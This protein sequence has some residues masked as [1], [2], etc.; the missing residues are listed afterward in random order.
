M[1]RKSFAKLQR[2]RAAAARKKAARAGVE[3]S[4]PQSDAAGPA[5]AAAPVDAL[6]PEKPPAKEK[7]KPSARCS[8]VAAV[9][10]QATDGGTRRLLK[11]KGSLA[12]AIVVP[13]P[14]WIEPVRTLF[15]TRFGASWE[16]VATDAWNST[17]KLKAERATEIGVHLTRGRPVVGV[18]AHFDALPSTLTAAAD[19]VI[20]IGPPDGATVGRAIQMFTGLKPPTDIDENLASVLEF[21]DLIAAFRKNSSPSDIVDRL[22]KADASLRGAG[23]S[24]RLPALETAVEYGAARTWGLSLVRDIA[25]FKAGRIGWQEVDRGAVLFSEPG[26]GKSLYARILAK[27]CGVPLVAF[28]IADLFAQGPGY[29]DSV[30]KNSRAMFE[31]AAALASPCCILFLDEIDALP[32]RATMSSRGAEWWTSVVTDFLLS[33]DSAVAGKRAGIVVIGATNNIAGVDAAILRPGRLERSIELVRPDH[34]GL[35]NVLRH[36]LDG[37]LSGADLDEVGHLMAGSTPAEIMMAVR[38]GRRIARYAGREL[39]LDDLI[40]SIAPVQEIEP[41]AL[42]RISIHEA[43]HAVSLLAVPFGTLQRCIIGGETG[44]AGRTF[45]E[46]E[47]NDLPTRDSIER[48]AVVTLAGR[49]AEKLLLGGSIALGS[50]GD[51]SSD[52]AQVTQFS[53]SLHASTGLAGTLIYLV[54]RQDALNAVR[55]DLKLRARVERHMRALHRR[56]DAVVRQNRDAIVAVAEQLRVRRRLTGDEIR[57]IFEA[58][59]AATPSAR[60][61]RH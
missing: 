44:S 8:L 4:K 22:R 35:V 18:A 51:D 25:D 47:T 3:A 55:S 33:L 60:S 37:A 49:A 56:A 17:P 26:L 16:V 24:E 21:H 59:A 2:H 38:G 20:R 19:V 15:P 54:S 28:S 41:K 14:S 6:P 52:L 36:H 53:V 27:A 34:A 23:S 11:G 45:F 10:R 5:P 57:K 58:T 13:G 32:N 50:G 29:L 1:S 43:A 9:F 40:E 30:I 48:R 61:T 42:L 46:G 12:V 7:A 39:E 31:K